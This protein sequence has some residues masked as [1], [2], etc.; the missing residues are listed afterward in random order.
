MLIPA[1]RGDVPKGTITRQETLPT[2]ILAGKESVLFEY[3]PKRPV[4]LIVAAVVAALAL[5][6]AGL[7]FGVG[8]RATVPDLTAGNV[9]QANTQLADAHLLL[10]TTTEQ[11]TSDPA[12]F[13]KV[14]SQTPAGKTK[15]KKDTK[16]NIVVADH[17]VNTTVPNIVGGTS[18][19]AKALLEKTGLT[20]GKI[21]S[22]PDP[23]AA[24]VV[25][26]Q[27]PVAQAST[28]WGSTVDLV[29]SS[30]DDIVPNVVGQDITVAGPKLVEEGLVVTVVYTQKGTGTPGT[31]VAQ[32][33]AGGSRAPDGTAVT[34]TVLQKPSASPTPVPTKTVTQ[35]PAPAPTVTVTQTPA[36]A[37]TKTVT[38]T[39][40]PAPAPTVTVTVTASPLPQQ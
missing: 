1:T 40:T 8:D 21:V 31:V 35:T 27:T 16:V 15:V 7:W 37:P 23:S 24:G 5:L 11:P 22:Q 26:S 28:P 20:V 32:N 33:P 4:G 3:A 10:G 6:G 30:G 13:G 34:V 38:Q 2:E 9:A 12:Q 36:P 39:A 29:V 19:E 18:A 17:P 14:L 25:L